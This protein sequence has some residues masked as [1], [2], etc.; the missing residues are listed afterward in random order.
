[1]K[2]IL[3]LPVLLMLPVLLRAQA[4]ASQAAADSLPAATPHTNYPDLARMSAET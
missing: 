3:L 4:P 1:M 2:K